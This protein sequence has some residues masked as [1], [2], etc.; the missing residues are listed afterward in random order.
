MPLQTS[1]INSFTT[2]ASKQKAETKLQRLK[3]CWSTIKLTNSLILNAERRTDSKSDGDIN[4]WGRGLRGNEQLWRC[5]NNRIKC[6]ECLCAAGWINKGKNISCSYRQT[7]I[8]FNPFFKFAQALVNKLK[9]LRTHFYLHDAPAKSPTNQINTLYLA[10][11]FNLSL[12]V[13]I[14]GAA[15]QTGVRGFL[16]TDQ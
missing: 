5:N 2:E 15:A 8:S 3:G 16:V 7:R 11:A 10:P 14:T 13:A 6:K 4:V 9:H 12:S 1:T